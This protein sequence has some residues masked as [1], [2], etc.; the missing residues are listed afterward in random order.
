MRL[1]FCFLFQVEIFQEVKI[2][3]YISKFLSM[4]VNFK[5]NIWLFI[6]LFISAR[7]TTAFL[8]NMY[9]NIKNVQDVLKELSSTLTISLK[10][11]GQ[12]AKFIENFIESTIEEECVY[13]CSHK[14]QKLVKNP[15]YVPFVN[16][17]GSLGLQ[18][19]ID[20]LPRPEMVE[21]CN[22]HDRCYDSCGVDKEECDKTFKRCLYSTCDISNLNKNYIGSMKHKIC[23][24]SAKLLFTATL[25]LGCASFKSAQ[26]KACICKP[27]YSNT[28]KYTH[29][30]QRRQEL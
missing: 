25:A 26:S 16:G 20:E 23:Q 18:L 4:K 10:T 11:I 8:D 29:S 27:F 1:V 28:Y 7:L 21:C 24:G 22:E 19:G 15:D 2:V 3:K 12:T 17:C 13:E 6:Y 5:I 9:D 14:E 30:K